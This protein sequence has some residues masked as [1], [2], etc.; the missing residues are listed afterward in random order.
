MCKV[1]TP[2]SFSLTSN[3]DVHSFG[4]LQE[5]VTWL[6]V[7]GGS[8]PQRVHLVVGTRT[9]HDLALR[10]ASIVLCRDMPFCFQI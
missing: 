4:T 9:N 5:N 6:V 1:T 7:L 10:T 8:S 3:R 2:S